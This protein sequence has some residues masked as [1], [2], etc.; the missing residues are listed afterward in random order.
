MGGPRAESMTKV[1]SKYAEYCPGSEQIRSRTCLGAGIWTFR[2]GRDLLSTRSLRPI[3]Q[4]ALDMERCFIDRARHILAKM[5]DQI[6]TLGWHVD[7]VL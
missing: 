2:S 4:L 3:G 6:R 7:A 5:P 1:N